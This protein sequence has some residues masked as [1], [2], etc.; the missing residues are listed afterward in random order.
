[1][2][3]NKLA[4]E[5]EIEKE[6]Y[7]E[8]LKL[9]ID[10]GFADLADLRA[11][12]EAGDKDKVVNAAHSLKGAAG[13][14]GLRE[15]HDTAKKVELEARE[16]KLDLISKDIQILNRNLEVYSNAMLE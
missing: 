5:L 6:D 13:S 1:M 11:A 7:L 2:N 3:I 9:F 15:F 8:L 14:L 10:T 12:V 4:Q 16:D